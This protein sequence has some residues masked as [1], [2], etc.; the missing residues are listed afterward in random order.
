MVK[1]CE[2]AFVQQLSELLQAKTLSVQ[3]LSLLY[4]HK[5][6]ATTTQVIE[7][8]GVKG[9]FQDFLDSR[10]SF[11]VKDCNV[12]LVR[13]DVEPT[14][15]ASKPK[16]AECVSTIREAP[17]QYK[18]NVSLTLESPLRRANGSNLDL[19]VRP[20]DL[21]IKLKERAAALDMIPFTSGVL[22]LD[23]TVLSDESRLADC[24]I[25]DGSSLEF[26]IQ[27]SEEI[28]VRQLSDLLQGRPLSV[29]DLGLVYGNKYGT[30]VDQALK[31]LGRNERF[32]AFLERQP[33]IS[34]NNG[35]V[36]LVSA[37]PLATSDVQN[38]RYLDLHSEIRSPVAEDKTMQT[39]DRIAQILK[40]K[41]YLNIEE[42]VK[43][44]SVARGTAILGCD[45][46]GLVVLL[47]GLPPSGHELWLPGVLRVAADALRCQSGA[48][49]PVLED[50][51]IE[52]DAVRFRVEGV[53]SVRLRFSPVFSSYLQALEAVEDAPEASQEHLQ[54]S[55][56]ERRSHF[57]RKQPEAAKVTMRLMKWW[58]N[59]Q[60]WS[61]E[62]ARPSDDLLEMAVA[63]AFATTKP[64]DQAAAVSGVLSLLARFEELQAVWPASSL[65]YAPED[66]PESVLDQRPLLPDP[67]NPFANVADPGSFDH[68]E[69]AL[70]AGRS[71]FFA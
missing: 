5:F 69:L 7:T 71:S 11:L 63:Y 46:A 23:G 33:C 68:S 13:E 29:S 12:T 70:I 35:C 25:K 18:V 48:D 15:D 45:D 34:V 52:Q 8:L 51:S 59:Q 54:A 64:L 30:T 61:N 49:K 58:R 28:L 24:G 50:V 40:E 57:V 65:G 43:D 27:A 44:G 26:C 38:Q 16:V 41:T 19:V 66:V 1:P 53:G 20:D 10:K 31:T 4:C 62:W 22:K 55:L 2:K 14:K 9:K 17:A 39:L 42:V 3:E 36:K 60:D 32:R 67:V 56:A 21:V 6:G 47:N 37:C